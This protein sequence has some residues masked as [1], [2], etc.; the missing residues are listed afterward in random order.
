[1]QLQVVGDRANLLARRD[2]ADGRLL[3]LPAEDPKSRSRH[4]SRIKIVSVVPEVFPG[5]E[6]LKPLGRPEDIVPTILDQTLIDE[7]VPVT[8]YEAHAMCVRLAHAGFFVGLSSG[9]YMAGLERS[10]A[11][12]CQQRKRR[13]GRR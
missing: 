4:Q 13:P 9:A 12:A 7:R 11:D 2:P 3:E 8:S 1:M 5:I 10:V 6:G